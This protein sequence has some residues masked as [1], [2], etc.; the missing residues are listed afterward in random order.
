MS[1]PDIKFFPTGQMSFIAHGKK[2]IDE[3]PAGELHMITVG[4]TDIGRTLSVL[5]SAK[6]LGEEEKTKIHE[7]LAR[8]TNHSLINNIC[9]KTVGPANSPI[10][11]GCICAFLEYNPSNLQNEEWMKKAFA[12]NI[13]TESIAL[14]ATIQ[15]LIK[16]GLLDKDAHEKAL[17]D[18]GVSIADIQVIEK[19]SMPSQR[20]Q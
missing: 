3:Y 9:D 10:L 20:L 1:E 6:G 15:G 19:C 7:K 11:E 18:L 17:K 8:A 2:G 4:H 16:V 14:Y 12:V 13:S 5:F